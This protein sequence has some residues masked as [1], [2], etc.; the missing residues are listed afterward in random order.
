VY[1]S[2]NIRSERG[3]K[4]F[5][6]NILFGVLLLQNLVKT[7]GRTEEEKKGS[8]F[9]LQHV[10]PQNEQRQLFQFVQISILGK[11]MNIAGRVSEL[12]VQISPTQILHRETKSKTSSTA[13]TSNITSITA[14]LHSPCTYCRVAIFVCCYNAAA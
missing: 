7:E 8:N 5:Q 14:L 13:G 12:N 10:I 3:E 11:D 1:I 9:F 6:G 2:K 4:Y